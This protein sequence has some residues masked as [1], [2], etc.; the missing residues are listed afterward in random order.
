[1]DQMIYLM[2]ILANIQITQE[3]FKKQQFLTQFEKEQ[4]KLYNLE[5]EHA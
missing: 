4:Y 5:S 2:G 3:F 1:M